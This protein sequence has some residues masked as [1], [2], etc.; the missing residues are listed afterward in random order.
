MIINE[1]S[2]PSLA[3]DGMPASQQVQWNSARQLTPSVYLDGNP[4]D[5]HA[6]LT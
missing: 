1:A 2:G 6:L 4:P 5:Y 3:V